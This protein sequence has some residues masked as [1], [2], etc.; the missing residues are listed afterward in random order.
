MHY[1]SDGQARTVRLKLRRAAAS[2][3]WQ[4]EDFVTPLGDSI[5]VLLK[6]QR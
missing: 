3:C 2:G 6:P 4:L 5:S 1:A